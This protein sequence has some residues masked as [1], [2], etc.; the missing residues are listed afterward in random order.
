MIAGGDHAG[1]RWLGERQVGEEMA[2]PVDA[3]HSH[4]LLMFFTSGWKLCLP[5]AVVH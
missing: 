1:V 3:S 2:Q 4:C 5:L